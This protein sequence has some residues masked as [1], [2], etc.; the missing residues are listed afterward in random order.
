[1]R[2]KILC[3]AGLGVAAASVV[4]LPALANGGDFFEELSA[5]WSAA[6]NA[7]EGR[8]YFGFIRDTSGKLV[9]SVTVEA[10]T[11]EG[12]S[13]VVQSDKMGHYKIPG[14]SKS[15]DATKVSVSC[16]KPGYRLVSRDRRIL[17]GAPKAPIET[18]CVLTPADGKPAA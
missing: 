3:A 16:S 17:R 15:V 7:D 12:S 18:D 5:S 6:N 2:A 13:F 1:M 11:A 8:S 14:F 10:T 4:S 9:P